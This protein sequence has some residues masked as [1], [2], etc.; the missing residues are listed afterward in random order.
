[1]V[2]G[3]PVVASN[4]IPITELVITRK[5]GFLFRG[6]NVQDAIE[7]LYRILD[8]PELHQRMS[9]VRLNM[10]IDHFA[11]RSSCGTIY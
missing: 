7:Q 5:T 2:C 3:V 11:I 4:M 1:M 10:Y 8:Y 6:H 9:K